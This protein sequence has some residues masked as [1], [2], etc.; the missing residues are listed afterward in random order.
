MDLAAFRRLP[1][2]RRSWLWTHSRWHGAKPRASPIRRREMSEGLSPSR[3]VSLQPSIT[4]TL[5][6]LGALEKLI[7]CTKYC[8]DVC[9]EVVERKIPLVQDSWTAQT[10]QITALNPD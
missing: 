3:I 2:T 8:A 7:A 6:E 10:E 5:A 1:H 4:L 9:A